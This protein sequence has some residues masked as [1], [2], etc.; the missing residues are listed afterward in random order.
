MIIGTTDTDYSGPLDNPSCEPEDV[1]YILDVT[2]HNFPSANITAADVISTWAGLRP[3]IGGG[4]NQQGKPSDISRA[5]QIRMPQ[6]G[7]I[8]VAGG[9]LTTYRLM[10]EQTI[11]A[12]VGFT[13]SSTKP[14]NTAETPLLPDEPQPRFSGILPPA[15]SREAVEHYCRNEW[16]VHLYDVMIRRTSWRYY[17]REHFAIAEQVARWM[18]EF[19]NWDD[20]RVLREITE[21]RQVIEESS[22]CAFGD[23]ERAGGG[24]TST[25]QQQPQQQQQQVQPA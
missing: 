25:S 14:A 22:N 1:R 24:N 6:P 10:A 4:A 13:K 18:A 8:D 9:K 11:D 17:H 19:L 15:V 16:A 2:H 7:W 3:L 21:Y 23:A 20:D 5:H 12:V